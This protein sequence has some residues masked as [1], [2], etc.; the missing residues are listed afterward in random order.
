MMLGTEGGEGF[1]VKVRGLPWSCSADEVQRF[2]S[3]CKIQN[4]AQ[5]IRFIYTREGRPSGE[6]FVELESEDEVK[7]ALKKD[8]ET[9]GHRYVEVFKS[10]NVEMDWVL[11]HTGPNSPDTA[12]DGF[13]RLR[14]LPFGCSKE[15]IVQFFSGMSD[16]RY[17]DGGSTFQSTTGHCVHMRGLPYRATENDIYNFFS[18]LNPVRVHIEIGPDGRVTGE[19]DVEFATHE[20]AVAAMSKD[21]ANMQHRYV[22]LFLNSTAGASG[23]AYEHRY[24]ELFLNSTAGA[25]GGAYGSQMMG[26]MGLSNQSSYGGPASQQLSGGYGGGYGGQSSMSGYDQVLQENS[27]DFQSNIA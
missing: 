11:K 23:G 22:E 24:V 15:E 19:A 1:V 14:G 5:G 17:G 9:M 4:G 3:D 26:G 2:F 12:N 8:R 20:D 27:S 25:S 13:V 6:A 10:N 18:P 21:K 7:L 16:H